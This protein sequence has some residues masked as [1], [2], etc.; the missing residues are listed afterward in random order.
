MQL[1]LE[2][3]SAFVR[4]LTSLSFAVVFQSDCSILI[5]PCILYP[6][7]FHSL[8][9]A[10][11]TGRFVI[12][13]FCPSDMSKRIKKSV[14]NVL[15][16]AS[17]PLTVSE[18]SRA[19]HEKYKQTIPFEACGYNSLHSFLKECCKREILS[20]SDESDQSVE[21]RYFYRS[22]SMSS[23]H[24]RIPNSHSQQSV[25]LNL[26]RESLYPESSKD[27]VGLSDRLREDLVQLLK[28]GAL[29]SI[30]IDEIGSVLNE[31]TGV[32]VDPISK[33]GKS[34]SEIAEQWISDGVVCRM[35][36]HLVL[37]DSATQDSEDEAREKSGERNLSKMS[38]VSPAD[39]GSEYRTAPTSPSETFICQQFLPHRDNCHGGANAPEEVET[40]NM[41]DTSKSQNNKSSVYLSSSNIDFYEDKLYVDLSPVRAGIVRPEPSASAEIKHMTQPVNDTRHFDES[42]S[43]SDSACLIADERMVVQSDLHDIVSELVE[44]AVNQCNGKEEKTSKKTSYD[45]IDVDTTEMKKAEDVHVEMKDSL[46][47]AEIDSSR[48]STEEKIG[49]QMNGCCGEKIEASVA[50]DQAVAFGNCMNSSLEEVEISAEKTVNLA[51][52][53]MKVVNS[54]P[55]V[56]DV[57]ERKHEAERPVT[58][59][60]ECDLNDMDSK[61]KLWSSLWYHPFRCCTLL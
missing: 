54:I 45:L 46:I 52:E 49:K 16:S 43:C 20:I 26:K 19:Y 4:R 25:D 23:K 1:S 57:M 3:R 5:F 6:S 56:D 27:T 30:P 14:L 59:H 58:C 13:E 9:S 7:M 51:Q 37:S 53:S 50:N 33:F 36:D 29:F 15:K 38:V 32:K 11:T 47:V 60:S 28:D 12:D 22:K 48:K 40:W 10:D 31:F 61:R 24:R 17:G 39:S 2:K 42:Q 35:G 18:I 21:V 34:W 41:D 8:W 44:Y 55:S